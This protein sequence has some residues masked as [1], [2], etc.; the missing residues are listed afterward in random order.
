MCGITGFNWMDKKMAESMASSLSHR[1]LDD[2]GIY[3]DR[4]I[5][6]GHRRLSILDLS[7]NGHQPMFNEKKSVVIVFNG[8]IWNYLFLKKD[9]EE[10][11]HK[12]SSNSDT[13]VIIHGYEEY[14]EKICAMLDGMFAFAI[15]DKKNKILLLARDKMGKKPLYYYFNKSKLVFASEIKAI[16]LHDIERK[17]SNPC[18]SEYLSLRFSSDAL[19]MFEGIKKIPQGCYAILSK[20]GLAI[21]PYYILPEFTSANKPDTDKTD[22]LI[23]NAVKKRLMADVPIGVFLSG[24]LDSS[25]IVAYMSRYS[26]DIR[27]FSVGFS[28]KTDET[29][30]ARIIAKQFNTKHTEIRLDEDILKYLPEVVYHFDEPL[31]DPAALP[32]F[33]LCKEVSKQVKVALSGEGGDEVFGG[34]Q[35]F[36]SI[37][38]LRLFHSVPLYFRKSV[39]SPFFKLISGLFGYPKKQIFLLL[40]E[41]AKDDSIQNNFK[42]LF[43]FP[44][45]SQEKQQIL[46]GADEKDSFDSLSEKY[47]PLDILAQ[48]YY[49]REWLPNDLLMKADKMSMASGL[50]VRTPFLDKDLV[51]YFSGIPYI[52]K[53]N[54]SLFR[55]AVSKILP[56][57]ITNKKKQGFTLPLTE[58]FSNDKIQ[59]R[60]IPFIEKLKSRNIFNPETIQLL[61]NNPKGFRNEHKLWTLLNFEIWC[62]IYIDKINYK[63]IQI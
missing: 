42:R 37:P 8:E 16:L 4:N 22:L 31:A 12:F 9:L 59:E 28:G 45:S 14:G 38:N 55:K 25:A 30:Y 40:S 15:W 10:K 47:T 19:T 6:L 21:K 63:D 23:A 27:T 44:F 34:Y 11:G 20:K 29:K 26:K 52:D 32:T 17:I 13:E 56:K 1:G 51:S 61:I 53:Y 7:K 18:L 43:Y 58:W 3:V 2:S 41:M 5:S 35:T 54:R 60:I 33:L 39:F 24:G 46:S 57:E 50:E 36:N 62:E 49:F 48:N